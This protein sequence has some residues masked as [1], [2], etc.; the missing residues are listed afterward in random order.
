[1]VSSNHGGG[2]GVVWRAGPLEGTRGA[3]SRYFFEKKID[4]ILI[5]ARF[6]PTP[7]SP[8]ALYSHG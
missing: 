2:G 4:V 7:P 6:P 8:R 1:M 5:L 3:A